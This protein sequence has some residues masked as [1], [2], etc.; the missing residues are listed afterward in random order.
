[1]TLFGSPAILAMP[2][3]FHTMTTKIWSLLEY[4]PQLGLAAAASLPLLI[5][6]I[7]LMRLQRWMLGRRTY[8][9]VGSRLG[10]PRLVQLGPWKWPALVLCLAVLCNPIFLP[11]GVLFKTAFTHTVGESLTFSTFTLH[12]VGFVFLDFSQ[13]Q[14]ALRNT[15]ILC[16]MA[17]T[18][19]TL[20]ALLVGY[21]TAREAVFGHRVLCFLATAP[22]AIPGLVLGVGLFLAYARPPFTLYGTLWILLLAYI[23]I[24]LPSAFQQFSAAFKGV[25]PELEE[26]ARILG[27]TRL[28]ALFSITAPLLRSAVIAAWCFIF[29]DTMRELSAAIILVTANTIVLSVVIYDLNE[30]NAL[31]AIAVLGLTMMTLTF[32]VVSVANRLRFGI[33][34]A[35]R[36]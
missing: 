10:A 21:V 33:P 20:L 32:V 28:Y 9:I 31:G 23:T 6:T 27:A 4:P 14:A 12:N 1:M 11:Y 25:H 16:L 29:I 22:I 18:L 15:F 34:A 2:A 30:T 36:S 26:A 7:A 17:A 3:G 35:G 13:T 24:E 5:I 8:A 19:G